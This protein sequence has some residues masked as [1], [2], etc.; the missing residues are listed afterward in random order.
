MGFR[1]KVIISEKRSVFSKAYVKMREL[2]PGRI[3]SF[4]ENTT[5]MFVKMTAGT[6]LADSNTC[7]TVNDSPRQAKR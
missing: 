1:G 4:L 3:P 7:N 6:N 2:D 5:Q